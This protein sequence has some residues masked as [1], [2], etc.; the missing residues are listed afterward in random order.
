[1]E[2][3]EDDVDELPYS[4]FSR[5]TAG[6]F[7]EIDNGK[8]FFLPY[9]KFVDLIETLGKGFHSKELAGQLRK[10]DP[11]GSGSFDHFPF[12]RWYVD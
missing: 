4:D 9:S 11:N 1:M 7:G 6:V 2:D 12:V 5:P 3:V 10:V 8:D